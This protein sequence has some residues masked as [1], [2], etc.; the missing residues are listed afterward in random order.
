MPET[1]NKKG[2]ALRKAQRGRGEANQIGD[3]QCRRKRVQKYLLPLAM[4]AGD[5]APDGPELGALDLVLG[6]AAHTSH[7]NGSEEPMLHSGSW[8]R[9]SNWRE[10]APDPKCLI[11]K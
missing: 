5:L 11:V 2:N 3:T 6:P 1:Q 9:N 8:N 7:R 10:S 4:G